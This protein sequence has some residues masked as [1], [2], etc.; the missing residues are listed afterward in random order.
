MTN[1]ASTHVVAKIKKSLFKIQWQNWPEQ[2]IDS[3][4]K[5][6][7]YYAWCSDSEE[8]FR[9]TKGQCRQDSS[10]NQCCRPLDEFILQLAS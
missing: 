8:V 2:V 3:L 1:G 5:L 6:Q 7:S 9:T 4:D 10:Y